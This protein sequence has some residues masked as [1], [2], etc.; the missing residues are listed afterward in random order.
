MQ[1]IVHGTLVYVCVSLPSRESQSSCELGNDAAF[2]ARYSNNTEDDTAFKS[3]ITRRA[4]R[5][6]S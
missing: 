5:P 3:F 1:F 4:T 2:L 6:A